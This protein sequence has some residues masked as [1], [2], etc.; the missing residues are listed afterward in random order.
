MIRKSQAEP[1][2]RI[3]GFLWMILVLLLVSLI[4]R[5]LG[6]FLAFIEGQN[7]PGQYT[8]IGSYIAFITNHLLGD[9]SS[10]VLSFMGQIV[11]L[12]LLFR[13][14]PLRERA[15]K[16]EETAERDRSATALFPGN[17]LEAP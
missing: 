15:G 2:L 16:K 6:A 1:V 7:I 11:G 3:S 8:D 12:A 17:K 14:G 10:G 5:G 9:W 4:W 13:V